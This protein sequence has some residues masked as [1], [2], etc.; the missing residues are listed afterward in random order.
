VDARPCAAGSILRLHPDEAAAEGEGE[1]GTASTC[2]PA[3]FLNRT[4][5]EGE[6]SRST[7]TGSRALATASPHMIRLS[8]EAAA[9]ML[10][11]PVERVQLGEE[12]LFIN[13]GPSALPKSTTTSI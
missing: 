12:K 13:S 2:D 10:D 7:Y 4:K 6:G 5:K 8:S 1:R 3:A 11:E 9:E